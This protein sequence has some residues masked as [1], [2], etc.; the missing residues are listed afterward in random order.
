MKS[1]A[2]KAG[3]RAPAGAAITITSSTNG[4]LTVTGGAGQGGAGIGG[5][6]GS[7]EGGGAITITGGKVTASGGKADNY[8]AAGAGIGGGGGG[9]YG[10]GGAEATYIGPGEPRQTAGSWSGWDAGNTAYVEAKSG[11]HG[12]SQAIGK[13]GDGH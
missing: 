2:W 7:V 6:G 5:N 9:E 3:L 13:G 12:G 10:A 4:T 11:N 8:G 1:G